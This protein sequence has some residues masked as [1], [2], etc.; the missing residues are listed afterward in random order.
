MAE[1]V[2]PLLNAGAAIGDFKIIEFI[3]HGG[4]GQVYRARDLNHCRTVA[5]KIIPIDLLKAEAIRRFEEEAKSLAAFNDERIVQFFDSRAHEGLYYISMEFVPGENLEKL[6]RGSTIPP[7]AAAIMARDV[8][9]ALVHAHKERIIHRDIKP[10]N[11]LVNQ[12]TG[13]IKVADFGLAR[14]LDDPVG[15]TRTGVVMGTHGYMS[16][17][18]ARGESKRTD[19][20][21]DVYGVGAT[22]YFILTRHP[23]FAGDSPEEIRNRTL[24]EE[25]QPL[26]KIDQTIPRNLE[27]IC[28]KCLEKL[29]ENRYQSALD[30]VQDLNGFLDSNSIRAEQDL[31]SRRISGWKR[32]HGKKF[33]AAALLIGLL[34]ATGCIFYY[35][36]WRA[37]KM[38]LWETQTPTG[39]FR[40]ASRERAARKGAVA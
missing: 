21:T 35:Q 20:R 6:C 26:R 23:P 38:Q 12:E 22:L 40:T 1:E 32:R 30:L 15:R 11:I 9:R 33:Y 29:P 16:P 27:I 28:L 13:K 34:V 4:S 10:S 17:E 31:W 19:E 18:Q 2:A 25:P 24:K 39:T 14:R 37:T 7:R 36:Q 8:A 5:L 3:G